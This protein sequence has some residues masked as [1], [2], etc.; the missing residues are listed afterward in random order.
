RL[1]DGS[2][3]V[4]WDSGASAG[5][6]SD[7]LSVQVQRYASDGS[8][9]GD[10]EQVNTTTTGSQT[11]PDVAAAPDGGFWVTWESDVSAG[12][13]VSADSIQLR[14]FDASGAGV[15][16][17][18][19][20]NEFT[21]GARGDPTIAIA[22]DGSALFAWSAFA[23][24]LAVPGRVF[25]SSGAA[26]GSQFTVSS[27]ALSDQYLGEVAA[28]DSGDFLVVW[29]APTASNGRQILGRRVA[30]DGAAVGADFQI[31]QNG[32]SYYP[33]AAAHREG[34]VAV[35]EQPNTDAL[36]GR[37]FDFEGQ[38]LGSEFALGATANYKVIKPI[39]ED[40]FLVAWRQ[41][42]DG[43]SV[44]IQGQLVDFPGAPVGSAF[45]INSYTT[46]VQ[47]NPRLATDVDRGQV[48]AVWESAGSPEDDD[49]GDSV[50]AQLLRFPAE[51]GDFVFFD[52][53]FDGVQD[54][55]EAGI[56]GVDVEL[57]DA[58]GRS[59]GQTVTDG[60]GLYG[61]F[62]FLDEPLDGESFQLRFTAP[63]ALAFTR[64]DAGDDG[65]DSDPD[66]G[67][68]VTAPFLIRGAEVD[69]RH[70]AGFA[71]GVGNRV[72]LD[73]DGNGVQDGGE[74]GLAGVAVSLL[75]GDGV[76]IE[77]TTTVAD[78]G[79]AFYALQSGVYAI[80]VQVPEGFDVT[81]QDQGDDDSDSDVNAD[82]RSSTF[83]YLE[84]TIR[85]EIDAGLVAESLGSIGDRVWLDANLNG[86]QDGGEAG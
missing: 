41:P 8:P 21:T 43:S 76:E 56:E 66:P 30:T 80:G 13:S 7:Q 63:Q 53:D 9:L 44:G 58:E 52:G 4:V 37:F 11:R 27:P 47:D 68:G 29:I 50:L 62:P 65:A 31:S 79:Y 20:V 34:F 42:N 25:D 84:G 17:E 85:D 82:G 64:A 75:D 49:E 12:G 18:T 24:S 6:D 45:Q 22:D 10:E 73:A 2:F 54:A 74:A 19:Q 39:S 14:R 51:I 78:G 40:R 35:W 28:L 16:A 61:F 69:D 33:S 86:I 67:A 57:L 26:V 3:V 55:A 71:A 36:T 72:W 1:T 60:D 81:L 70:D 23:G 5:D 59:I 46:G 32:A 83:L 48:L 15:G 77:Q 38:A